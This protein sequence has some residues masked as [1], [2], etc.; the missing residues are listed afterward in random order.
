MGLKAKALGFSVGATD[1]QFFWGSLLKSRKHLQ[2]K[3]CHFDPDEMKPTYILQSKNPNEFDKIYLYITEIKGLT[4]FSQ[5]P[6]SRT[7]AKRKRGT[8]SY[9]PGTHTAP[10]LPCLLGHGDLCWI[11][12]KLNPLI[13]YIR[14]MVN[15]WNQIRP[16]KLQSND[17][18]QTMVK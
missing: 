17:V 5:V 13:S 18:F 14:F 10:M 11:G 6:M 8:S 15:H 4:R 12:H 1:I 7:F 16:G 2:M 3:I 9:L